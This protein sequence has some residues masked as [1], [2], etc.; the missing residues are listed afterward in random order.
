MDW[1]IAFAVVAMVA[2]AGYFIWRQR[3]R[4]WP[5]QAPREWVESL[6]DQ[7]GI[8]GEVAGETLDEK[9]KRIALTLQ[10][11]GLRGTHREVEIQEELAELNRPKFERLNKS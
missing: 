9:R 6:A 5:Q 1:L 10:S 3:R 4:Y 2:A 7:W 11:P 8:R